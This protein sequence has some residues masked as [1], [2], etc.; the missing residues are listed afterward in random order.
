MCRGSAC[1]AGGAHGKRRVEPSGVVPGTKVSL[2]AGEG[3]RARK[4]GG[5]LAKEGAARA[6]VPADGPAEPRGPAPPP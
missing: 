3:A 2:R 4:A 1:P 5:G 6:P